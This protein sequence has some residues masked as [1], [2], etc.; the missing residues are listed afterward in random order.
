M[1]TVDHY[2]FNIEFPHMAALLWLSIA[3]ALAARRLLARVDDQATDA[4]AQ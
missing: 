1:G 3:L 4:N 2:Y